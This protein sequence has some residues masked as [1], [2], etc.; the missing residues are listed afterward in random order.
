VVPT[1]T[2]PYDLESKYRSPH[3]ALLRTGACWCWRLVVIAQLAKPRHHLPCLSL[4]G[5]CTFGSA[6]APA[7][8][9]PSLAATAPSSSS[10]SIAWLV[11]IRGCHAVRKAATSA[12][13]RASHCLVV[14]ASVGVGRLFRCP[15]PHHW[16]CCKTKSSCNGSNLQGE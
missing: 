1:G 12:G 3:R 11:Y 16:V 13:A 2:T 8:M 7:K 14:A 15:H 6:S 10:S 4:Q 9:R 5:P